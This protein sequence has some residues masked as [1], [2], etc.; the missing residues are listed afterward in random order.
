MLNSFRFKKYK[1][2]T[3]KAVEYKESVK[4]ILSTIDEVMNRSINII[5]NISIARKSIVAIKPI[6]IGDSFSTHNISIKRPGDGI[7]PMKWHELIGT[8]S[9]HNFNPDDLIT[10]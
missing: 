8:E 1:V 5:K 2:V 9:K 7:S 4:P 10:L 3:V 6:K